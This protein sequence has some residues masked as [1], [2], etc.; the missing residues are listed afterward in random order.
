MLG[1]SAFNC[2]EY[3][4]RRGRQRS[5]L[6]PG[7]ITVNPGRVLGKHDGRG[8]RRCNRHV[9]ADAAVETALREFVADRGRRP[10]QPVKTGDIDDDQVRMVQLIPRRKFARD[11]GEGAAFI[12][13]RQAVE[14]RLTP[15]DW[16]LGIGDWGLGI[17]D[18][19]LGIG[20]LGIG[21]WGLGIGGIGDWGLGISGG[22]VIG[23]L[24]GLMIR[25][26][27]LLSATCT[28]CWIEQQ[29]ASRITFRYL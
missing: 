10:E 28:D 17:G 14:A 19:G 23:A 6:S 1:G 20:G 24:G 22:Q 18:W 15:G 9:C 5:G 26:T 21:D 12:T 4:N 7:A 13:V 2:F 11:R 16:G 8:L 27:R 3:A 25:H 29:L